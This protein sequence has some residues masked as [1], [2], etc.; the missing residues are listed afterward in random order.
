MK[1]QKQDSVQDYLTSTKLLTSKMKP[2]NKS[3]V[4]KSVLESL[5]SGSQSQEG[6]NSA[7]PHEKKER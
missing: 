4:N 1:S 6:S 7:S 3:R 5:L 2:N